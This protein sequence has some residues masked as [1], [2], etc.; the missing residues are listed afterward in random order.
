VKHLTQSIADVGQQHAITVRERDGGY[1]LVASAHR[2]A[3]CRLLRMEHILANVSQLN[4]LEAELLEIDE[5]FARADL[6]RAQRSDA[7]TRREELYYALNGSDGRRYD[8]VTAE[9][10][11]QSARSVRRDLARG[12]ALGHDTLGK[13]AGTSL[14]TGVELDALAKL[15]KAQRDSVVDRAAAGEMSPLNRRRSR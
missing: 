2:V 15:P 7:H 5:N 13:V 3:A 6:S 4:D 8:E 11:G 9:A 12:K 1:E 10:T 14:D